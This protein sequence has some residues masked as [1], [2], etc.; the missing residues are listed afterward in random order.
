MYNNIR[1]YPFD[2]DETD[3]EEVEENN[4]IRVRIV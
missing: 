2:T 4:K 1:V 3:E